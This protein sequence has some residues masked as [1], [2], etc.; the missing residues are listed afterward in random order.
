M[1]YV[2]YVLRSLKDGNLYIGCTK[3]LKERMNLHNTGKV[4]STKL[5]KPLELIYAEVYGNTE[6]KK[7][8]FNEKNFLKPVGVEIISKE[9]QRTIFSSPKTWAGKGEKIC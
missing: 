7:M 5:R 4:S 2:V 1:Y 6:I 9:F 8:L 3:D